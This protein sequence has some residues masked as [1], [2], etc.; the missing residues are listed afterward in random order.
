[1]DPSIS[2]SNKRKSNLSPWNLSILKFED[3]FITS[4]D[5]LVIFIND[6]VKLV[7]NIFSNSAKIYQSNKNTFGCLFP[8]SYNKNKTVFSSSLELFVNK[9][10]KIAI[11]MKDRETYYNVHY[12]TIN[13]P[14]GNLVDCF[15]TTPNNL[16]ILDW[17]K[18][19]YE[20]PIYFNDFSLRLYQKN[21]ISMPLLCICVMAQC[22]I[23]NLLGGMNKERNKCNKRSSYVIL[24]V[25]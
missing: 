10:G 8:L 4:D 5:E 23:H 12:G 3:D 20:S 24:N 13:N 7:N 25:Y 22:T 18:L 14:I 16:K 11:N 1:M 9:E 21:F 15:V 2:D 6:N 19:N 17:F